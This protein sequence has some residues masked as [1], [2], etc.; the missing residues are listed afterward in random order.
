MRVSSTAFAVFFVVL[1]AAGS[2]DAQ[3]SPPAFGERVDVE[4]VN[5]DVVVTD[6]PGRRVTDLLR[7]DFRLEVDGK[8]VAIDYF[9]RPGERNCDPVR[10]GERPDLAVVDLS[11]ANLFVF[12]DQSALEWRTSK[13]ILEEIRAFVLPRTGGNER[14]MIAAFAENLRILSPPTADRER[15]EQAFVELEK[16]RAAAAAWSLAE[17]AMLERDVRENGRPR[18]QAEIIDPDTG[19]VGEAQAARVAGQDM[20]TPRTCAFRSRASAS[21]RST[22]RRG[23]SRRCASGSGRWRRSTAG[24]RSSSPPPATPRSPTPS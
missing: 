1:A 10:S 2:A 20:P 9:A 5:V 12:V 21:S 15:I 24:S 17:R 6:A 16:L 4:V 7:E 11:R 3:E 13:Q 18:A 22:A 23:R 14:I 8:P 19:E